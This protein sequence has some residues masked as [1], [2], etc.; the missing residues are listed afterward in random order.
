MVGDYVVRVLI[1]LSFVPF[2]LMVW[3][4]LK[5]LANP[6]PNQMPDW[7]RSLL[8]PINFLSSNP[9]SSEGNRARQKFFLWLPVTVLLIGLTFILAAV[10]E[11]GEVRPID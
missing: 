3:Y 4:F 2:F 1:V 10:F 11:Y 9:W 5:T 8:G 6:A 7:L